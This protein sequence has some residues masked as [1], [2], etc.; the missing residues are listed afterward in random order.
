MKKCGSVSSEKVSKPMTRSKNTS[1]P[2]SL[3]RALSTDSL[4]SK[5]KDGHFFGYAQCDLVVSDETKSKFLNFL[6]IFKN[7][8]V[9]RNDI[10][11]HT[12]RK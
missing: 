7:T 8:E 11:N 6:P 1:K 4:L 10:G 9:G 12:N 5:I 3:K 2:L